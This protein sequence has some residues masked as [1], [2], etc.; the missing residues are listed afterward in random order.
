MNDLIIQLTWS[1]IENELS[2]YYN[3]KET[4]RPNKPI[5]LMVWLL[6][7]K[8]IKNLS[9]ENVILRFKKN[10]YYQYFYGYT[11]YEPITPPSHPTE[12]VK[13]RQRIGKERG[14]IFLN[15]VIYQ[16]FLGH[17]FNIKFFIYKF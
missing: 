2:K 7:L 11:G 6:L 15:K 12:L 8:Q 9:D 5:R 4:R 14:D 3:N 17:F 13:F 1:K 10:P 16:Q